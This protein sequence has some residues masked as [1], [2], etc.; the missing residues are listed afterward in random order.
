LK[1]R[2]PAFDRAR[3]NTG[4]DKLFELSLRRPRAKANQADDLPLVESP[5]GVAE[6]KA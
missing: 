3:E 2:L 4:S 1:I 6:Q 5:I